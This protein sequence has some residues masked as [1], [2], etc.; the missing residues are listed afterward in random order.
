[1]VPK[2]DVTVVYICVYLEFDLTAG[3][4]VQVHFIDY[5]G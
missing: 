2:V 1:M 5:A 4:V 3:K